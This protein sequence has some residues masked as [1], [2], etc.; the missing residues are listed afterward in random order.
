MRARLRVLREMSYETLMGR[1]VMEEGPTVMR[2]A[3]CALLPALMACPRADWTPPELRAPLA[4]VSAVAPVAPPPGPAAPAMPVGP[5]APARDDTKGVSL[6]LEFRGGAP[7]AAVAFALPVPKGALRTADGLSVWVSGK[8]LLGVKTRPLVFEHSTS[9]ERTGV[10]SVLVEL[11]AGQT[12]PLRVDVRFGGDGGA[13]SPSSYAFSKTARPASFV[14]KTAR[15]TVAGAGAAARATPVQAKAVP[16]F[17]AVLPPVVVTFPPGYVAATRI[18]GDLLPR[19]DLAARGLSGMAFLSEAFGRFADGAMAHTGYPIHEKGFELG[20]EAWLY[21]RCASYL[22]AYADGGEARHFEHALLSCAN[23]ARNVALAG[24]RRGI[25]EGKK[26]RDTKYSHARG[27]Y[28]YFALT[29]DE[30]AYEAV[31]AIA[32]MWHD[33]PLFVV[34]YRNGTTRGVDKLWTER[35]LAASLEGQVYGFML[36]GERRFLE[37]ARAL[38]ATALKHITTTDAA[39]LRAITKTEFPPQSCFVHNALQQAEGN[40]DEPWCSSWM[41]ELVVDP[42]M[43]YREVTGDARVD[44]VFVRLARSMR[45]AGT[46]Y[47]KDNPLGDA[48]LSPSRPFVMDDEPRL[49]APLYGYGI[50]K[51]GRRKPSGEWSDFEHCPDATAVTAAALLALRRSGQYDKPP[52]PASA[53]YRVDLSRFAT[54]GESI[55]ALHHELAFCAKE[56]LARARRPGRD[57]DRVAPDVLAKA[58][59]AGAGADA[60]LDAQ[61]IGWPVDGVVP[62]R[63]LSW[64]FNTSISELAWLAEAK[65]AVPELRPGT[66]R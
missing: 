4:G 16:L 40:A 42:L 1:R 46:M 36:T 63:K 50:T 23:Y 47:F 24:E 65:V 51:E 9:G 66:V 31:R 17:D 22:L 20:T 58:A 39:E 15:W 30:V 12:L 33:D 21:D 35:L 29:G 62:M 41:A 6:L 54:E 19:S 43:R 37:S 27:L 53:A 64:W 60:V 13:S 18:L 61:K 52:V 38:V 26:D 45:D 25:F 49:L 14:V 32:D 44:E 34:P 8:R 7:S 5:P 59:A 3:A 10:R 56:T 28:A 11:P 2:A 48:F 55:L 57:P